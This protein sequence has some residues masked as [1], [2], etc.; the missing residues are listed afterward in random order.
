MTRKH[1]G[2]ALVELALILPLL[3]GMIIGI[4]DSA[5]L[6]QGYLTA[7][8]AAREAAR[9]AIAYQP[10]KG[11][12][13]HHDASGNPIDEGWPYCPETTSPY[14]SE[15]PEYYEETDTSYYR[16]RAQL[17]KVKAIEATLG[18]RPD[19]VCNYTPANNYQPPH[20]EIDPCI[21]NH[22]LESGM[23]GVQVWGLPAFDKD[24][25][26]DHPGLQGL[27]VRVRVVHNVPLFIFDMFWPHAY[28]RVTSEAEMIN[29][30]IQVGYGNQPPPTLPP[31]P[32][33]DPPGTPFPTVPPAATATPGASPT[34]TPLPIYHVNL[35]F[36]E[37]HNLL[38]DEREH[39]M[40]AH[41]TDSN[42]QSV[43]GTLVMFRTN[44]GS[45]DYSGTGHTSVSEYSG[46]D[47]HARTAIYANLP[48]TAT[49]H[50]WLDYDGDLIIDADEPSDT[51]TK[52]WTAQNAYLIVSNHHPDPLEWI[53]ID[54][55]DHPAPNNPYSLWWCPLIGEPIAER[56]AYPV[57]V[58]AASWDTAAA[59]SGQVPAGALG[60][61]R[62][63]SHMGDGGANPCGNDPVA[64][65]ADIEVAELPPDLRIIDLALAE[66]V[67][68]V[69]GIPITINITIQ[70]NSPVT[71][72]GGPFD[73]DAYLDLNS[74][75]S[76]QQ[77]G[78]VKQWLSTL[79]PNAS[80][81]LTTTVT[82][83]ELGEHT[84]WAQVDT[85]N[86]IDEGDGGGE[87]NNTAGP[88]TFYAMD[89][90]FSAERSDDFD[91]GLK[92]LWTEYD[93]RDSWDDEVNGSY[94]INGDGQLELTSMGSTLWSGSNAYFIYQSYPYN[95]PFDIR[96]RV[97]EEPNTADYAKVGLHLR[98]GLSDDADHINNMMTHYHS[99][100]AEQAARNGS[101]F[102]SSN[103]YTSN[104]PAWVRL[105]RDVG[106][107]DYE[108]FYTPVL[109]PSPNDWI[110]QGTRSYSDQ[111][112]YIGIANVSYNSNR[113]G[114]G[115]VD[116]FIFCTEA[117][118]F[119]SIPTPEEQNPPPGLKNC[120][121]L[122][123]VQGFEGNPATVF[124]YWTAGPPNAFQRASYPPYRGSFCM[125]MHASNGV[126][127]CSQNSYYP[128]LYQEITVPSEV[129]TITTLT[130]QG[131]YYIAKSELPCS[132]G[133]PDP[134]DVLNLG[135]Q[136]TNGTPIGNSQ[137]ITTG[138]GITGTW[139]NLTTELS[140]QINLPDYADQTIRIYWDASQ[141]GDANGTYF[142]LDEVSAQICTEWPIPEP[143]T[144][145]ASIGGLISTLNEYHVAV[146]TSNASV[147][148]YQQGGAVHRTSTIQDGTYHFY[149][150]APGTYLIYA[151]IWQ[152]G[153]L[154]TSTTNVT[155]A[156]N[157][158]NYSINML[159][160]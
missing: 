32:P 1:V 99:P 117:I 10:P 46:A 82:T 24:V 15:Y 156:N 43:A 5:L 84:L 111:M 2:Q 114:T 124:D 71:V 137:V 37:A 68:P 44:A 123:E 151:E 97:H 20:N 62:I 142:F 38:P 159:L 63:E 7:N 22:R 16:R 94:I 19:E 98:E 113:Y 9:W 131:H 130:V 55:M 18:L 66:G 47:G 119:G 155:V 112:G 109:E 100:A 59:V 87:L 92:A 30:G 3:I 12:C 13:L 26:E 136:E 49:I 56:L 110:S 64:Y 60:T 80:T 121:S 29:E 122:L 146:P 90:V 73:T 83:Y 65:S 85:S 39:L 91:A 11:E 88:V 96:L 27:P 93:I 141:D 76:V 102:P 48:L 135:L 116:D 21:N 147:Q 6:V 126:P 54:L 61:Y 45:F 53:A 42:G 58:E 129:Y 106:G 36:V 35:D 158:R 23:L 28:V 144:G 145:T 72:T 150:V 81:T 153:I 25:M 154:H 69:P 139:H 148:A 14:P 4:I 78:Q 77:L 57:N 107:T 105:V 33:V 17:I 149:N 118:D 108:A 157:E 152:D 140:N 138:A 40:A 89:C 104:L 51:A 70:N 125:R 101:R 128:Y 67:V 74:A 160:Q 86:Y 95:E 103:N 134:D 132:I 115:V 31:A 127:P 50:A 133:G 41:V 79:G 34:P 120:T 8:H 75:P 143:I 52:I